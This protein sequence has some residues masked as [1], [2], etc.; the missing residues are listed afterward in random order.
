MRWRKLGLVYAPSGA[1][2]W[3]RQYAHLPTPVQIAERVI[4]IYFT[5]LDEQKFG[6]IGFVD[7][8]ADDP[9]R[10]LSESPEPALDLGR[11]GSFDDSGVVPA[12][13]VSVGDRRFLYYIGWQRCQR[14]PYALYTGLAE[15]Q[16]DGM[17]RR[18]SHAPVMDRTDT[19]PF[20]RSAAMVLREGERWRAWYDSASEWTTVN[21]TMYPVYSIRHAESAEGIRWTAGG[22]WCIERTDDEFGIA[23]PWVV[24][25]PDCYRMW[26]SIRSHSR[27][28]RIGYA[29]SRDGLSWERHD[30]RAGIVASESGWDSEMVCYPAVIDVR[31]RRLMF[32][33]GNRHGATGFGVA[34]LEQD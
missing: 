23:R 15:I 25:D 20:L 21:G 24:R 30:D 8:D 12:S 4:R 34:V 28:Y 33:N 18:I 32:F 31:G 17:C 19:E 26:Y 22:P 27:P 29:E 7:V 6:R 16:S 1:R 3:A 5:G 10:V 2:P 9:L 11:P 13:I 14:V